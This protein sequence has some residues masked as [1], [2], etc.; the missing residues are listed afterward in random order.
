MDY[1]V[2]KYE[3]TFSDVEKE[4]AETEKSLRDMLEDLEGS[5]E[6]ILGLK[7]LKKLLGGN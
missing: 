6:D 5:E 7:E 1:L 3:L 4:I 2:K